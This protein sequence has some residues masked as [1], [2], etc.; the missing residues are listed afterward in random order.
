MA[1]AQKPDLVFQQNGRDHQ[2][3]SG[4]GGGRFVHI[5]TG[6][7]DGRGGGGGGGGVSSVDYWQSRRA[8]QR[9][10]HG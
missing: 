9:I 7:G 10:D 2:N 3:R 4:G 1:H 6:G 8:D 5:L